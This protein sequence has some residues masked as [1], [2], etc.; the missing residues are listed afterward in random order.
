MITPLLMISC[1]HLKLKNNR[2]HCAWLVVLILS[3]LPIS[4]MAEPKATDSCLLEQIKL[5][6]DDMSIGEIKQ[7]CQQI[8]KALQQ[9]PLPEIPS[10]PLINSR[11]E[12]ERKVAFNPYVLT[13]HK[14]NYILPVSYS[15][16]INSQAYSGEAGWG[17]DLQDV[18]AKFQLSI[19]VP[20]TES[21]FVDGDRLAFGFTLQSWWQVYNQN[22]SRPFRE[23]NYQP[24]LFYFMPL[25][26]HPLGGDT[27]LMLGFEHQSN[28][29]SQLLS[30][31]WNRAYA[32]LFF[33]KENFVL[34]FR[35][36]W[37][38]SEGDEK[39][40]PTESGDDN[41]DIT[42]YMGHFEMIMAYQWDEYEFAFTGRQNFSSHNGGMELGFTFPL[43]GRLKGYFQYTQGYG[44]SLIDYNHSQQRFG[45]GIALTDIF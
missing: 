15:T 21:I 31:S 3:F 8:M 13:P 44:E 45:L 9:G 23:T 33:A 4:S 37:R 38:I 1:E 41:P 43:T 28:G 39:T 35:P 24:E 36:W 19:K 30:R 16:D 40:T 32:N 2:L 12:A 5:A 34:S 18:E 20:L 42:D 6:D 11:L 26:Y 14:M 7:H 27:G 25:Q 29:R 10:T 17:G 22:L